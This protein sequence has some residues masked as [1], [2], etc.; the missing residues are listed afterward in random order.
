VKGSA[1][2]QEGYLGGLILQTSGELG[3]MWHSDS[4]QVAMTGQNLRLQKLLVHWHINN[5]G[6]ITWQGVINTVIVKIPK[7]PAVI[8]MEVICDFHIFYVTSSAIY[9]YSICLASWTWISVNCVQSRLFANSLNSYECQFWIQWSASGHIW[10]QWLNVTDCLVPACSEKES[11][12]TSK[13]RNDSC[14]LSDS[15][16]LF[17]AV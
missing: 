12:L 4:S 17:R 1:G 5:I 3:L 14:L 2:R 11:F 16:W 10:L 13:F 8:K 9:L 15:K 7:F 6:M